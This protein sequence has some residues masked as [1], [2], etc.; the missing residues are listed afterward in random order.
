MDKPGLGTKIHLME[1]VILFDQDGTL[2]NSAPGIKRCANFTL[3]KLDYPLI[4]EKELDF[5]IGPPLRDCFRLCKVQEKDIEN[6][7]AIYREEYAN[8]GKY[9]ALVYPDVAS[10]LEELRN[11]G[12]KLFVCTSKNEVLAKD[13][14]IHFGL[15]SFFDGVYG[16][17][18]DGVGAKKEAII[19]RCLKSL[20][21][22]KEAIMV[23]DTELDAYGAKANGI[24]CYIFSYGYGD[25]DKI[26]E[27]S[28]LGIL[29]SFKELLTYIK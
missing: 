18:S 9:E 24:P 5:F 28:P 23:G 14:L 17:P 16:A 8:G 20:P 13:I 12:Y 26:K 25:K 2:L 4:P 15:S 21:Q 22:G 1:K 7:T 3:E 10:T 19:C 11:R 6:A 27:L 29:N